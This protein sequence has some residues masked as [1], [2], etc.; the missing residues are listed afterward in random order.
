MTGFFDSGVGGIAILKA[1]LERGLDKDIVYFAINGG[2]MIGSKTHES[3]MDT[4]KFAVE[5]LDSQGCSEVYLACNTASAN[6]L[7]DPNFDEWKST[8]FPSAKVFG[9][10]TPT[11]KYLESIPKN[12]K[13]TILGTPSTINSNIY[14]KELSSYGFALVFGLPTNLL[15]RAVEDMDYDRTRIVLKELFLEN[16]ENIKNTDLLVL[17]CTHYIWVKKTIS[18]VFEKMFDYE[19]EIIAQNKICFVGNEE[20]LGKLELVEEENNVYLLN[21]KARI[22]V[23]TTDGNPLE[24]A[25]KAQKLL[26]Q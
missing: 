7:I 8:Y 25:K 15:A 14:Q 17:S 20:K 2:G 16:Y 13:I 12:K 23:V 3:I 21:K 18:E 24:F 9:I 10:V 4:T 1:F 6:S 26:N 5:Y 22:K 19:P 11:L